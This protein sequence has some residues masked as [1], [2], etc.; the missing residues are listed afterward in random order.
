M[1]SVATGRPVTAERVARYE[2]LVVSTSRKFVNLLRIEEEDL[3]QMLREKVFKILGSYDPVRSKLPEE[4]YVFG[5]L[6]NFITDLKQASI[7]GARIEFLSL[8]HGANRL[9]GAEGIVR[10]YIQGEVVGESAG[11]H[12]THCEVLVDDV[13]LELTESRVD[14]LPVDRTEALVISLLYSKHS[15]AEIAIRL[16]I[17]KLEVKSVVAGLR[18][19]FEDLRPSINRNSRHSVSGGE[20]A[21]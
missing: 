12:G 8:E 19:R 6:T 21:A 4:R 1:G 20:M 2:G 15:Y 3:K 13:R 11:P 7:R 16:E 10:Q 14:G 18:E 5:C 17:T 9:G